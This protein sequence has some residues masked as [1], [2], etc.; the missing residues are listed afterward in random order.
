MKDLIN[1]LKDQGFTDS[2]IVDRI[3]N[4]EEYVE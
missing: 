1:N 4:F 2:Q 3:Y